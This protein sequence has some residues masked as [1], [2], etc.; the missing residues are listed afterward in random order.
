LPDAPKKGLVLPGDKLC[1][2]EE[3]TPR[4]GA[5]ALKDGTVVALVAGYPIYD[6]RKHEVSVTP[7]KRIDKLNKGDLVLC[8]VRDVQDKVIGC[9]VIAKHGAPLKQRWSG[10]IIYQDAKLSPS[11]GDLL[12]AR[13]ENELAGMYNLTINERG[14][15]CVAAFC[16]KCGSIMH[17]SSGGSLSC[18]HCRT[19][20]RRRTVSYYGNIN[21]V[22]EMFG[23]KINLHRG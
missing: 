14:L 3:Y 19:T 16:D 7:L 2:I 15:G 23:F 1:V 12:I 11:I 21:K 17:L 5:K 9:D 8:E 6:R 13:V 4:W 18:P 22:V 20:Y 10:V